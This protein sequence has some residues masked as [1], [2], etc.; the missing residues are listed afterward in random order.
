MPN[1]Q[2]SQDDKD[3]LEALTGTEKRLEALIATKIEDGRHPK[4][5]A[6]LLEYYARCAREWCTGRYGS[7]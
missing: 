7:F 5:V 6:T 4:D 3:F 1:H 2:W